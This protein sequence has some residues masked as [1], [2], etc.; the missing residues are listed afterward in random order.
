MS[1]A[2][3]DVV[4]VGGGPGGAVMA[5]LL[6]RQ[7]RRVALVEKESFPRDRVG[8]SITVDCV[9]RLRRLK[10]PSPAEQTPPPWRIG[11]MRVHYEGGG[12]YRARFLPSLQHYL[13]RRANFDLALVEAA[14]ASGAILHKA[15]ARRLLLE[16]GRAVGVSL[17]TGEELRA[18]LGVVAAVG[19]D[20]ALLRGVV[21]YRPD[22]RLKIFGA[23]AFFV[24]P[25]DIPRDEVDL[26]VSG[27]DV[28]IVTPVDD[29]S[30]FAVF[31]L[32]WAEGHGVAAGGGGKEATFLR[33]LQRFPTLAARL[34]G[35][36]REGSIEFQTQMATVSAGETPGGLALLG[37]ALGYPD[38]LLSHGVDYAI[39]HAERLSEVFGRPDQDLAIRR[40]HRAGRRLVW[41]D[42]GLHRISYEVLWREKV[43]SRVTPDGA[44]VSGVRW[45]EKAMGLW[46][47]LAGHV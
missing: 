41:L 35:A 9:E 16:E 25:Y 4:V 21:E 47:R 23:R 3:Y 20:V 32:L 42:V 12:S 37:N 7:G 26:F 31:F 38:P 33:L 17:S 28:A 45:G 19:R 15:G 24:K 27:R 1:Q 44:Q 13:L 43:Y 5:A 14:Q 40:F 18:R 22:A 34:Q 46:W 11:T 10:L 36:K 39:E 8:E 30:L 6:G 2:S 29:G